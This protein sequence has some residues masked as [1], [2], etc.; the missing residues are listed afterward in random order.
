[1]KLAIF[2]CND[3]TMGECFEKKLFGTSE[4]YGGQVKKGDLLFLYNYSDNH[5]W[6]IWIAETDSGTFNPRAWGGRYR[7]QV[8][9]LQSSKVLIRFPRY[10]FN[11]VLG[12][13]GNI[14]QLLSGN[15]AQNLLQYFAHEYA[16]ERDLG[17]KLSVVE[18][19]FRNKYPTNFMCEDGHRV[20]STHEKIIDDWLY[21]HRVPHAYEPILVLPSQGQLIPDFAVHCLNGDR[22]YIEYWGIMNDSHY[23][24][25]RQ[26]KSRLYADYR[27]P[28]I[29]LETGDLHSIEV[30]MPAKLRRKNIPFS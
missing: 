14:G 10:C 19:D 4:A 24:E 3:T 26:H 21:K 5:L 25:R 7:N 13:G 1:M 29:E 27:L 16:L 30:S 22:I 11:R 28:L 6:G 20:R 23:R 17:I 12:E 9:I 8:K 15:K 2:L 18:E